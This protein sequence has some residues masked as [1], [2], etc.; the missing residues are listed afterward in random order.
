MVD[1][2]QASVSRGKKARQR[3]HP[4]RVWWLRDNRLRFSVR[5]RSDVSGAKE[6]IIKTLRSNMTLVSLKSQ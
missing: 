6:E 4:C 1:T 2:S 5:I 3:S